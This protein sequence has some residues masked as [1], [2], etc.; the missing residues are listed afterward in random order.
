MVVLVV[1]DDEDQ[2]AVRVLLLEQLGFE[3]LPAQS[4][5]AAISAAA[6]RRPGGAVIDLRIPDEESGWR[7]IRELKQAHAGLQIFL[8]SGTPRQRIESRSEYAL[9]EA[10]FEKGRSTADLIARLRSLH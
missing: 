3:V 7:L 8:L 9:V 2:L 10:V 6:E 1:E 5:A 4:C